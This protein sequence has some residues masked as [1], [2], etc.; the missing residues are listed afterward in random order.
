ME[1]AELSIKR[2]QNVNRLI[3][4]YESHTANTKDPIPTASLPKEGARSR[5]QRQVV[6]VCSGSK[7]DYYGYD[8]P[9]V[10]G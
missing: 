8:V 10:V 6:S 4:G 3:A 1:G 2:F 9:S 7:Q 5:A